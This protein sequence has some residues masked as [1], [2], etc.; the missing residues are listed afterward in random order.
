MDMLMWALECCGNALVSCPGGWVKTL[1]SLLAMQGWPVEL[2]SPA[3]SSGKMSFGKPGS[4]G[5]TM[6]KSLNTMASLLRAG[7]EDSMHEEKLEATVHGFPL[8]DAGLHLVSKRSN[9]FSPLDL[10]GPPR[11]EEAQIYEDREDRQRIFQ[12]WFQGPIERGV[13]AAKQEGGEVG[14]AASSVQKAVNEGMKDF[15]EAE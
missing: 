9:C 10:F 14:R 4:E 8:R 7:F 5:K 6:V 2:S 11:N 15:E 13:E 12:K 1:K 3:W